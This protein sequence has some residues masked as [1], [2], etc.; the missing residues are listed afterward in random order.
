MNLHHTI[1]TVFNLQ[2]DFVRILKHLSIQNNT[3]LLYYLLT[4]DTVYDTAKFNF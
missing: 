1:K 2:Y 4:F 3:K